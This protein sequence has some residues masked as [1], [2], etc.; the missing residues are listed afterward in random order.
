M[1]RRQV[2]A[3]GHFRLRTD[4]LGPLPLVNQVL[5]R[6]GLEALVRRHVPTEDR[7]VQL[8]YATGLGV[9]LRSILVEREPIYRQQE[10]VGTFEIG[11][12]HV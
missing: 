12:V 11:R 5:E 7:R 6:L 1:T 8:P 10:T 4:R 3:A 9:L 2:P